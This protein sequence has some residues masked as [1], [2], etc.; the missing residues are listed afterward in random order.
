MYSGE[1]PDP[2]TYPVWDYN[3]A[4]HAFLWQAGTMTD[5]NDLSLGQPANPNVPDPRNKLDSEGRAINRDGVVVGYSHTNAVRAEHRLGLAYRFRRAACGEI[6]WRGAD[7]FGNHSQAD[8]ISDATAIN[9]HGAIVGIGND[10]QAP[11]SN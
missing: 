1:Y 10:S 7:R 9:D 4:I 8:A 11:F 6:C 5:L 3:S 2:P